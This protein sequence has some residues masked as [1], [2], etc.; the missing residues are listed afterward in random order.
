[1]ADRPEIRQELLELYDRYAHGFITRRE[2]FDRAAKFAVGGVTVAAVVESV[3]PRYAEAQQIREDDARVLGERVEYPSPEG[4]GTMGGYLVRPADAAGK[5]PGVVVIHENRGLN[6]HIADVARRTALAGCL[7]FAPDV[8]FPLGGYPGNDDDGRTL[9]RQRDRGEMEQDFIAAIRWLQGHERCT[10]KV[11]CIGF[12]FGGSMA[13]LMAVRV[14]DLA[15]AVPF[16]GSQP[17]VD[18][19][20]KI[21]APL[22]L[23]FG[24][25]DERVNA[26][27]PAYEEALQAAGKHYTAHVYEGAH[28]GFHNDTT[29]RYD[30]AAAKLAWQR[31]V[32]FLAEHLK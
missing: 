23:H 28:H 15:A 27:W 7:A 1:M 30:E 31:T 18:E 11:A 22:L 9:Q 2:L 13:N 17:A 8:L 14:P 16:Y 10:G 21:N 12:C 3:M 6:P 29:P 26:S 4:A 25:L 19:A 20:A 32:D 24:G 5:L